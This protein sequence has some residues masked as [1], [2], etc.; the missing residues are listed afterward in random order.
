MAVGK[1]S[2]AGGF[3]SE[4]PGL[5]K[6]DEIEEER[7]WESVGSEN[8][9]GGHH[10][11]ETR[12]SCLPQFLRTCEYASLSTHS[13]PISKTGTRDR[14]HTVPA[15]AFEELTKSRGETDGKTDHIHAEGHVKTRGEPGGWVR[16]DQRAL[17]RLRG[18]RAFLG[19]SES[20]GKP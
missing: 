1:L 5:A 4:G 18:C 7:G 8:P 14:A 16:T 3:Y 6:V 10:L 20:E 19:R 11:R 13:V 2:E 9:R 17:T 12:L 15:T